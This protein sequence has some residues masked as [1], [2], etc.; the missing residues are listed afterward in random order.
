[1]KLTPYDQEFHD[2]KELLFDK[3]ESL[4]LEFEKEL[5]NEYTPATVRKYT[6]VASSFNHYIHDYTEHL[7]YEEI[8]VANANSKFIAQ[9]KQEGLYGWDS[10]EI[11]SK[12]KKFILFLEENDFH[13][14]KVLKSLQK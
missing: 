12:L 7:K 6:L 4:I 2:I 13:N 11:K 8:S 5:S 10:N 3:L 9:S 1:M 14:P